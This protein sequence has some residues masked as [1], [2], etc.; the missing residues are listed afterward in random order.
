MTGTATFEVGDF[1]KLRNHQPETYNYT[2]Q[3]IRIGHHGAGEVERT[4]GPLKGEQW[5]FSVG[6][7]LVSWLREEPEVTLPTVSGSFS[8]VGSDTTK[9][10]DILEMLDSNRDFTIRWSIRGEKQ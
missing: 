2:G 9:L 6:D 8:F 4:E 1:V 10:L 5:I 7:D 3:I